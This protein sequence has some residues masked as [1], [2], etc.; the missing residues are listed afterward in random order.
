MEHVSF[1]PR[2]QHDLADARQ[3]WTLFVGDN[4]IGR[5]A[6]VGSTDFRVTYAGLGVTNFTSYQR[7]L[8]RDDAARS[9]VE[10][11]AASRSLQQMPSGLLGIQEDILVAEAAFMTEPA[12]GQRDRAAAALGIS[13]TQYLQILLAL[14]DDERAYRFLPQTVTRLRERKVAR[15]RRVARLTRDGVLAVAS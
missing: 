13:P 4:A 5:V 12:P 2:D 3:T 7:H 1:V 6:E 10:S 11:R 8:S 14:I 15:Q 9:L